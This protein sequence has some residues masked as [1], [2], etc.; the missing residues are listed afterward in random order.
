MGRELSV[1]YLAPLYADDLVLCGDSEEEL[2]AMVGWFVEVWKRGGLK[3]NVTEWRR[4]IRV[5][6]FCRWDSFRTCLGMYI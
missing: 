5:W 2:R 3:V 1:E 6:G 4:G